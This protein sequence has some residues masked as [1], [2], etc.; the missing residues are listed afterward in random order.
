MQP[1]CRLTNC[2]YLQSGICELSHYFVF[3]ISAVQVSGTEYV[4]KNEGVRLFCNAT[5]KPDPP[6]DVEWFKN[7]EKI[8]SDAKS[9]ILITKKIETKVKKSALLSL[10]THHVPTSKKR[11]STSSNS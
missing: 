8:N 5:G 10:P 6:H 1:S 11:T 7:G 3:L 2:L 9:G 4:E